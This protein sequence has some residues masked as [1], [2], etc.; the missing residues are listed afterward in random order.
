MTKPFFILLIF[1]LPFTFF[2]F[3][4]EETLSSN[5]LSKESRTLLT[6]LLDCSNSICNDKGLR[7]GNGSFGANFDEAKYKSLSY[8]YREDGS[9]SKINGKSKEFDFLFQ[10]SFKL[11]NDSNIEEFSNTLLGIIPLGSK[12]TCEYDFY[13]EG[14]IKKDTCTTGKKINTNTYSLTGNLL[15]ETETSPHQSTKIINKYQNNKVI[16]TTKIFMSQ[17]ANITEKISN[18]YQSDN[19]LSSIIEATSTHTTESSN[20]PTETLKSKIKITYS[21]NNTITKIEHYETETNKIHFIEYFSENNN[22]LTKT[23]KIT[24]NDQKTTTYYSEN[25]SIIKRE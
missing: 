1:L 25:G 9:I 16:S 11:R 7:E 10:F 12:T 8:K 23:E 14:N 24:E 5:H 19:L 22:K 4:Y 21:K 15:E 18:T 17:Q 3:N 6:E 20:T 2:G 13:D